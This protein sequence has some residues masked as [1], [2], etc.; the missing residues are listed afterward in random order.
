MQIYTRS[1]KFAFY[2]RWD[3]CLLQGIGIVRAFIVPFGCVFFA[4]STPE[5]IAGGQATANGE[6]E[7]KEVEDEQMK[8][9]KKS[10]AAPQNT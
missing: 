1:F 9:Q 5:S 2:S 8:K 7:A 6:R 3:L 4:R 10:G